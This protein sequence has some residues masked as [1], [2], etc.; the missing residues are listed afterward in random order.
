[1]G[2]ISTGILA[3]DHGLGHIRRCAL[4]AKQRES[5]GEKVTL[6]APLRS[7]RILET[8][9]FSISGLSVCDFNTGTTPKKIRQGL[10][11]SIEWLKRLPEINQ[12]QVFICDNHPEILE[13]RPDAIISGQFFWHDVIND[14]S[15][16][17]VQYCNDLLSLH[18]PTV[19]GN[20]LFSMDAVR[21]QPGFRPVGH[22]ELQ[23]LLEARERVNLDYRSDLLITG[24]STTILINQLNL[25][26]QDLIQQGRGEFHYVHVDPQLMPRDAPEWMKCADFS[27]KMFSSLK[28]AICRPGLGIL[29]DLITMK[30]KTYLVFEEGNKEMLHNAKV[31]VDHYSSE[32]FHWGGRWP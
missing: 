1:M 11:S 27:V 2:V 3:C 16:D 24:G 4:M 9:F 25:I 12:Y 30:V 13:R 6:F 19:I 20:D 15:S 17:Y 22:F 8:K 21:S 26:I 5:L 18:A 31:M 7:I 23:E 10:E 29:T 14:A 28:A 32:V